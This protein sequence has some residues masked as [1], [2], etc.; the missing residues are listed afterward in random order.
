[1]IDYKR[2]GFWGIVVS[3]IFLGLAT[4]MITN[5]SL[6]ESEEKAEEF[7]KTYYT[8]ENTDIADMMFDEKLIK[9]LISS[10]YETSKQG[11]I[12]LK[13]IDEAVN[14]KYSNL[15]TEDAL[16]RASA[17]R[18]ILMGEMTAREYG[19]RLEPKK[20]NITEEKV[21]DSGI[22]NYSFNVEAL[23]K[24]N[25]GTDNLVN[26]TGKI[27]MVEVEGGWKV[28]SFKHSNS[29]F[30]K[31]LTLIQPN[32]HITNHSNAPI[33]RIEVSVN[34]STRGVMNA[35]NTDMDK[36]YRFDFQMLDLKALEYSIK[37]LDEDDKVFLQQS[38][39]GDFSNSKDVE[40]FIEEDEEGN[41]FIEHRGPTNPISKDDTPI[42]NN[43]LS[44]DYSDLDREIFSDF[45]LNQ[46]RKLHLYV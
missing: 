13:F 23:V 17:N 4:W 1:M 5:L 38:Y 36:N 37:L 32:L 10:D 26:L 40:L 7:L 9:S 31:A 16:K 35:D 25:D 45:F 39:I 11:I 43:M 19:T 46:N 14:A 34:G 24:F 42:I 41:L 18:T 8:I 6:N 28:D 30:A 44:I 2:P 33:R 12:E 15:M 20:I 22:I 29:N 21:S 3:L 27:D